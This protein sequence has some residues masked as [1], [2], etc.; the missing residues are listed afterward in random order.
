MDERERRIA[1]NEVVFREVNERVRETDETAVAGGD[2]ADFLCECGDAGCLERLR[3]TIA[4]YEELR[5]D[6]AQFAV[7]PGHEADGVEVVVAR[8]GRFD[9]V[10]KLPGGPEEYAV[11]RDPRS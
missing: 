2:E 9:V 1:E 11:A 4:E 7:K 3:M 5:S 6:P 8:E 10:R